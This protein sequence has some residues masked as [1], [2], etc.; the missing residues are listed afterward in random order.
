MAEV[1]GAFRAQHF[2]AD[3]T[4]AVVGL[5]VDMALR[6]RLAEAWPAAAGIEFGV[7]LE[8]PLPA[9]GAD[10]GPLPMLM[11]VLAGERPLRRLLAQDGILHR[12]QFLSPL[13]LALDDFAGCL[14][15]SHHSSNSS[16]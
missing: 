4:V 8:Q 2:G 5:F 3:H 6:R 10:I 12:G 16:F 9:T 11:F 14:G 1:A 13:G 7:R 15:V